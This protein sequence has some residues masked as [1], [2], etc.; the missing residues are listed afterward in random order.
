M[1]YF[2]VPVVQKKKN[3]KNVTFTH[4]QHYHVH[5]YIL[6]NKMGISAEVR[7]RIAKIIDAHDVHKKKQFKQTLISLL[8]VYCKVSGPF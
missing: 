2:P 7:A 5:V 4:T 6:A 1:L 8:V 3:T